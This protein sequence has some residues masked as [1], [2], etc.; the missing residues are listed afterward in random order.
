[1]GMEEERGCTREVGG[2]AVVVLSFFHTAGEWWRLLA[3]GCQSVIPA[4]HPLSLSFS[5]THPPAL[6]LS[7]SLSLLPL[8]LPDNMEIRLRKAAMRVCFITSGPAAVA[9]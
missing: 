8:S 5:L 6:S 3:R 7:L 1:M 2:T 4:L 9:I